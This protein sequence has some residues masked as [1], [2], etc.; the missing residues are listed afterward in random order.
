MTEISK[1]WNGYLKRVKIKEVTHYLPLYGTINEVYKRIMGRMNNYEFTCKV[2][3]YIKKEMGKDVP[4]FDIKLLVSS[5]K[6]SLFVKF[7]F[8]Y[9]FQKVLILKT[10][11]LLC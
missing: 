8:C 10:T 7:R 5:Q 4:L 6:T 1:R 11:V 2:L 3:K 9:K